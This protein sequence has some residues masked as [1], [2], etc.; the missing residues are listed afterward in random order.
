MSFLCLGARHTQALKVKCDNLDNGCQWVGELCS[1]QEHLLTCGYALLPCT[2]QCK[3]GTNPVKVLRKDLDDHLNNK[4]PRRQFPCQHCNENGEYKERTTA[5]LKICPKVKVQCPNEKC[6]VSIPRCDVATHRSTC[7]YERVPCKYAKVGCKEK[8]LPKDLKTHEEDDQFHL[9]VTTETV[10]EQN[11]KITILETKLS[12]L[13]TGSTNQRTRYGTM[14]N[15]LNKK[16]KGGQETVLG[17]GRKIAALEAK[18]STL[19]TDLM[20]Q[21]TRYGTM[22]NGLN[23]KLETT[24]KTT[25][26]LE[27]TLMKL[28]T[29]SQCTFRLTNYKKHKKDDDEIYGPPFYTSL[30][31]YKMC[32]EVD[33]NGWAS[34]KGTHVSVYAY[35]MK[36]DNDDS[37]TW[38]FTGTVTIELLNQ[39][40]DTNHHT[41]T[42]QF[43]ADH[44]ASK[45]VVKGERGTAGRGHSEIVPHTKL[46]YNSDNNCQYLKDNTLIFRISVQ[47]PDYKPWLECT[48]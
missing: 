8:P 20:N 30:T 36:G 2:N 38:P 7:P 47:V 46:D 32:I 25:T 11:K 15:D 35:L 24:N 45:R 44:K 21:R 42:L 5:H 43:P 23:K 26:R 34:G 39:L 29:S 31:G 12:S 17:Q 13:E 1:L 22:E 19:Q 6:L 33:A 41:F 40:E 18:L 16:L 48:V 14:E 27:T 4:C 3:N 9:R 10:L 28:T 37:L